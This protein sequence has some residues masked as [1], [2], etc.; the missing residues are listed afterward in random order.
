MWESKQVVLFEDMCYRG[1]ILLFGLFL[2]EKQKRKG[3]T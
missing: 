2:P 3:T 1:I